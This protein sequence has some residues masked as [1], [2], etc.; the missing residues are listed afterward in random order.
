[1]SSQACT[2]LYCKLNWSSLRLVYDFLGGILHWESWLRSRQ[3]TLNITGIC[4]YETCLLQ[5]KETLCWV[6]QLRSQGSSETAMLGITY[7]LFHIFPK[8]SWYHLTIR[9]TSTSPPLCLRSPLCS[10][11]FPSTRFPI[12]SLPLSGDQFN[13]LPHCFISNILQTIW[14]P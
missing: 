3:D 14:K 4:Y 6:R 11:L 9:C 5:T 12:L 10:P 2:V 8:D 1:M 13:P 7:W